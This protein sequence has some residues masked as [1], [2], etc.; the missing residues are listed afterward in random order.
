MGTSQ[1]VALKEKTVVV[2]GCSFGGKAV[3][4]PLRGQCK[5]IVIDPREAMHITIAAPRACV[6]PGFAKRVLIPLKEVFGD[7]FEQDTVEKIS[8]AAGQVVLSNGKEISYDYLVIATGTTGPFPGKLQ[9]DCTIDQALDLYKDAC[10]K[11]KAAKTVVIIGGGAVGVEIAGEVATDYP[12]KEVTIIHARD[13]LVEPATSDTFRASVQKQLEELNVKL[14]FGEKV[15]NLDDIPRD[16]SGATVLTDKGKSIQADV[17]FVCIGSSI[18]SQAYAEELGSKMDARGSLQVNQYLQVEGHENIFAVGDCCNADVQKMA[19]RA[20]EQ[21]KAVYHNIVQHAS[22]YPLKPY[23][24]PCVMFALSIGRHRGQ[25]QNGN[26]VLG[27]WLMKRVK[28]H[29]LFTGKMWG[30]CGLKPPKN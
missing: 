10:E 2:I 11:V 6:E 12:D 29:D 22:G 18:N 16:L 28:S 13:S 5:L 19:Y 25:L 24:S 20:G 9:N 4:Y 3:A 15:T 7:S 1:S 30:E 14:V 27:S 21:G 23:K 17:V 26:M 8:P